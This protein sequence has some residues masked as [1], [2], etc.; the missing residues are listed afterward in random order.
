MKRN[1][2]FKIM[3][4]NKFVSV[5]KHLHNVDFSKKLLLTQDSAFAIKEAYLKLRTNLT[6]CMCK[7]KPKPCKLFV[8]TS[9]NSAEGKSVATANIAISFAMLG[10]KTLIID[11]DMRKPMQAKIWGAKVK[12]GIAEH[13]AGMGNC[14]ICEVEGDLPLYVCCCNRIPSNPT[15]MLSSSAMKEML[16]SFYNEYDYI[17]I[18]TPP[19]TTVVDAQILSSISDGVIIIA[20]SGYTTRDELQVSINLLEQ[21]GANICGVSLTQMDPKSAKRA[22]KYKYKYGYGYK[23]G[24]RYGYKY[25]YGSYYRNTYD[26]NYESD[27]KEELKL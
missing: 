25:G 5:D 12:N 2:F 26:N 24:Y 18:D 10:K 22:G 11:A 17:F 16:E 3:K 9:A 27:V 7:D 19:I 6:F 4:K 20:K 1:K 13:L 21:V 23:Y 15:E 14:E 8:V